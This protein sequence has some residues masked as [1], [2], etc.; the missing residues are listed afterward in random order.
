VAESE[1]KESEV[2]GVNILMKDDEKVPTT[3][4]SVWPD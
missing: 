3:G 4:T 2:Q 1:G